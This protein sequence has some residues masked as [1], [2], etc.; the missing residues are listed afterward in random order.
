MRIKHYTLIFAFLAISMGIPLMQGCSAP[1]DEYGNGSTEAPVKDGWTSVSMS[2]EGL[3]LR[4]PLTRS[5]TPEGENST[6]AERIRLLV[7]DKDDK[8]SYEAKVTSYTPSG[9][10]ADKKGKGTMTLLAK[11]TPSGDTSTFVMLANIAASD[12]TGV[13]KLTGKTRE[14]VMELFTFSMPEKGEWKDGELP[15]WGVSDPVRVDH[16]SGAVPKLGIIYLVR[17]VARVDVGLNLSSTSEGASTFDEKA[18]GIEGITLTKVFFYNTNA[19]GRVSPFENE[20]YW[21]KANRKA[22]QPSIPDPAPAVTGKIDRTS[23][24]VDEKILLRE[25]YVPEAV[26]APTAATQGANGETLPENNTENY[27]KRPYIVVGLTGADKSRP[28]KETFFRIDYLKRT[29]AEADATY[30]YLPLLRNHRYLVNITEVGGPG[31]DTEEDARKGPAANIMY[32]VVVWSE[33]TMSN[34]QYD[35]Q[36]MLGVSDDHFT[37]YREGGSLMAK[38]QT[39]WPEGFTVEGLPAW[40]SY[41]IK[42]S[43]PGKAALTDEKIVTFTVTEQ[44]DTDRSWPEKP[45]DAQNALKAAYVKAGRMK[46]FLGFEQSKDINVT[47]RIFADEACSQPLEFIEVNQYG[48]SY[49]QSGKM[50]TKDGRTL[51]AEEA[52]AKVTFYVKTEPHD[53]EPVFH[54]EAA[55]PFKIEKADQLAGGVW[56]YMVTAP[57][58]TE[59]L[60]YFDNFNT[61]YTFTVTHAGTSRSASAKLSLLQKE[62]NAIPFFDKWLHQS[63]LVS[64]NSIYLMDGRQ[65]QYYVKA[66]SEYKVELVSALSD[67]GAGNVIETFIPFHEADPSLS[68]KPVAFTAVDDIKTPR[69]YSGK[70]RFKIYSPE[71]FFPEREFVV[72]L[73]SGIVQPESNT[74]MVKAGSKQ[75][76]F[77]PV[78]RVNTA[79]DYYKKLLDHD[80]SMSGNQGLPGNKEDFMLN[81]LD[82][83]DDWTVNILWTDIKATGGR[84]DIERA[85][86]SKLS[87]QGGSGPNSYIYVKPGQKPG[88]VLIE[89]KSGKIKGNPTLWSWH[90]W[91]VDK[92]PTVLNVGKYGGDGAATVQLMSHLLGAYEAVNSQYSASAY[93][94]FGMQY[95]WGRKDPFPA[96]D[97]RANT[98]F[99]DGNGKPFDFLWEQKGD[100][101]NNGLDNA[102]EARGAAM[103]MKQSIERPNSIVSHQSFWLYEC[104]PHRLVNNFKNRWVF[105]Y[106]WNRPSRTGKPEDVGGK[107]VFDPSPYGFRI[108]SQNEA[109]TL[110]FAYYNES[111]SGLKTPL[112]GSIYD[113]SFLN[114]NTGGN[115]AIFAVAQA[116]NDAHAGRYLLNST[117]GRPGWAP[118]SNTNATYRRC[119]TYSIRPVVDPEAKN[120]NKYLPK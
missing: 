27:L 83:D 69:L 33:S 94:E 29:G 55:N 117:G 41:S 28:D 111:K 63:L 114:G 88:N 10:P 64:S 22:K 85:G 66:N 14:E 91:I 51:T 12:E 42:P 20:T 15:M 115:E 105:L 80:A 109:V 35:G 52:G 9:V 74:Y 104:F 116:R 108:M 5:L 87:E 57:D 7:F 65:K 120:Y 37:F 101:A 98:N 53:L 62:Y 40:I 67:N 92:Y 39:S 112:P 89:I 50:V 25:V 36:Y 58:I 72:E 18:G 68:G 73:V 90:I 43:E 61:T 48:E 34:V 77:I 60:E 59:N 81:K 38:V 32:N 70:A 102:Q 96:H 56:R 8:F 107:T 17:A 113:G 26:N 76:I 49:G 71:G 19:E 46:W 106:P 4:N 6:A 45:E 21:D 79:Y 119:M 103:T 3:G 93:K 100:R 75:G 44:V 118:A 110:R 13:D 54:A 84:N 86:L 1:F 78:S 95:Q 11:N 23:S 31:F 30:E 97:V 2:V 82:T 16:S 99:Y 24:I 47:L